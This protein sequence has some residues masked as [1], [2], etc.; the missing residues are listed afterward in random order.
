[1]GRWRLV[2]SPD[3]DLSVTD[4]NTRLLIEWIVHDL[5]PALKAMPYDFV[6]EVH[7]P[8]EDWPD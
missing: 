5:I 2:I 3:L 1:M 8:E 7:P 4:P 6:L